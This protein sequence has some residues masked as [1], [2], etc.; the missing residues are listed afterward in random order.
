M[1]AEGGVCRIAYLC[2]RLD[3][4]GI[5]LPGQTDPYLPWGVVDRV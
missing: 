4:H 1:G 2:V 3:L 5:D